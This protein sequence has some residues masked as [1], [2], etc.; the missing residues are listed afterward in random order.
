MAYREYTE[1]ELLNF[2]KKD[3]RISIQGL[4]Q[5]LLPLSSAEEI[6]N[7]DVIVELAK[8]YSDKIEEVVN[9]TV[10]NIEVPSGNMWVE[11]A[12]SCNCPVPTE[13]E[14]KILELVLEGAEAPIQIILTDI[15]KKFGKYP[16]NKASV[17]K[18]VKLFN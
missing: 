4:V 10:G 5:T 15:Y 8:Q 16:K 9:E 2:R 11:A 1:E 14:Q 13:Q 7:V 6:K 17:S 12:N 3:K 18:C